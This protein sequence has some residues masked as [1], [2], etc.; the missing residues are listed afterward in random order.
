MD[1]SASHPPVRLHDRLLNGRRSRRQV[2]QQA[3]VLGL[4]APLVGRGLGLGASVAAQGNGSVVIS[5]ADEPLTLENWNS[6]SI[7]GHPILRNVMEALLNRDPASNELV[8]EL[9]TA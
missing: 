7:Y 1:R 5:L 2:I 8:S 6:F 9:A 4:S 3:A